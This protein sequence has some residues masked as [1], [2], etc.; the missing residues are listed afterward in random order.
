MINR[1]KSTNSFF[2]SYLCLVAVSFAYYFYQSHGNFVLWLNELHNPIWDFFFKYWTH[3]GGAPFFIVITIYLLIRKKRFAHILSLVGISVGLISVFFKQILFADVMRPSKYFEGQATIFP[4]DGVDLLEYHSFPSGHSM[5]A[6][7]LA[8]FLV[9]MLQNNKYSIVI[10]ILATL[11]ALSRVYLGQHFLLDVV[12]GSLIGTI[13]ATIY[14]MSF[15][16]Y[17]N[18]ERLGPA[19]TPDKDLEEMNLDDIE[20]SEEAL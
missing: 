20:P 5:T 8:T 10:L 17:L 19:S 12:A 11:T 14:Y 16:K 15:E 3:S 4:I 2:V 1:F 9:L 18:N 6:F 13:I 7:A